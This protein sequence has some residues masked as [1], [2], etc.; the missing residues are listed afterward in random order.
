MSNKYTRRFMKYVR[1]GPNGSLRVDPKYYTESPKWKT[2]MEQLAKFKIKRGS[3][4][5]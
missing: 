3:I 2:I 1:F 4:D 5:E